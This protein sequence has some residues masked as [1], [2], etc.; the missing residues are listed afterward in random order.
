MV[1]TKSRV[2]ARGV[3]QPRRRNG[4]NTVAFPTYQFR[5]QMADVN[6]KEEGVL[7]ARKRVRAIGTLLLDRSN[8]KTLA[9]LDEKEGS[10]G[11]VA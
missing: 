5:G 11:Y 4:S 8:K 10:S 3:G 6:A 1:I 2:I 7:K 9:I